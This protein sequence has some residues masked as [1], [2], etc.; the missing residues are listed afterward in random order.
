MLMLGPKAVGYAIRRG[1]DP[2]FL[3]GRCAEVVLKDGT[4]VG[5][6]GTVHPEVLGNFGLEFPS[7]AAD[8]NLQAFL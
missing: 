4:V 7:S 3:E 2:A 8:L 6:F 5:M 1:A